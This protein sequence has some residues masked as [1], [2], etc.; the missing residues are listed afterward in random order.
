MTLKRLNIFSNP[1]K[2]DPFL[3]EVSPQK[4]VVPPD[5][6]LK[7]IIR[8]PTED[9][10]NLRLHFDSFY[11]MVNFGVAE[12]K[13]YGE[14]PSCA[15]CI[16]ELQPGETYSL[17]IGYS[18]MG[19]PI[20]KA[21]KCDDPNKP[22]DHKEVE[23]HRMDPKDNI[24]YMYDRPEGYLKIVHYK[25]DYFNSKTEDLH[26]CKETKQYRDLRYLYQKIRQDQRRRSRWGETIGAD[27]EETWRNF[28][29]G[30]DM[31]AYVFG[32]CPNYNFGRSKEEV[33]EFWERVLADK[34]MPKNL[35]ELDTMTEE[36]IE[37]MKEEGRREYLVL[38]RNKRY[39]MNIAKLQ[40]EIEA[41]W[42]KQCPCEMPG[43]YSY[44]E[45]ENFT[46]PQTIRE[47]MKKLVVRKNNVENVKTAEEISEI[48]RESKKSKESKES[49]TTTEETEISVTPEV[50]SEFK[51]ES[52]THQKSV[53]KDP[54][55][56]PLEIKEYPKEKKTSATPQ[57]IPIAEKKKVTQETNKEKSKPMIQ[58]KQIQKKKNK[59][60]NPCCTI[61]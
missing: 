5:G 56:K 11:F 58:N 60:R 14:T 29:I 48:T 57:T 22:E 15:Y 37:A 26:L 61:A 6:L 39:R 20:E 25:D 7:V 30:E 35:E 23:R 21:E 18:N 2:N 13:Q 28:P 32:P 3:M 45:D 50:K 52:K 27:G 43:F 49:K 36:E 51:L 40:T 55:Q 54:K 12:A 1:I 9:L 4:L 46:I 10:Q 19:Y 8:N 16:H 42:I 59:K 53:K 34:C 31:K 24:F 47:K 17:T 38:W 33:M 41:N 44:E